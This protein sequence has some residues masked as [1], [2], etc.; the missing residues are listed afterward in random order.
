[1][2]AVFHLSAFQLTLQEEED[3]WEEHDFN[4]EED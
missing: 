3:G 2:A 4:E 1:M